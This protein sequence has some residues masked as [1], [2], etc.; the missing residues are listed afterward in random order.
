VPQLLIVDRINIPTRFDAHAA[1]GT[2]RRKA[3][4]LRHVDKAAAIELKG[5][6]R[7]QRLEVDLGS[8]VVERDQFLKWLAASV[9]LDGR[10][11]GVEDEAVVWVGLFGSESEL[12]VGWDAWEGLDLT[13][14]NVVV[15]GDLVQVCGYI[16]LGAFECWPIRD[17]EV[18]VVLSVHERNHVNHTNL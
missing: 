2:A 17:I 3:I 15:I 18:A 11:I 8:R 5:G 12:L 9:D 14:G 6:F 1:A 16:D 4:H 13:S 10:W 7:A